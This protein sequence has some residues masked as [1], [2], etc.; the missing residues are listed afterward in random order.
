[1]FRDKLF[2][3]FFIFSV[4]WHLF[5]FSAIVVILAP[6]NLEKSQFSKVTFLGPVMEET[7]LEILI[8]NNAKYVKTFYVTEPAMQEAQ[9]I[10]P[11]PPERLEPN[12][13][14]IFSISNKDMFSLKQY[15]YNY[16]LYPTDIFRSTISSDTEDKNFYLIDGFK[17]IHKPALPSVP[18]LLD[19]EQKKF[20]V[21]LEFFISKEG[22]AFSINPKTSSGYPQ[23]DMLAIQY[24]E[25]IKFLPGEYDT[26]K[27]Y[28]MTVNLET[29]N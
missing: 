14:G 29:K 6:P 2:Q 24:I 3:N 26:S 8:D 17:V 28:G 1:M 13:E 4:G 20:S 18:A 27:T 5:W 16:K 21:K 25:K 22:T 11:V 12:R 15:I 9:V 7:M 10:L 19:T 23:I